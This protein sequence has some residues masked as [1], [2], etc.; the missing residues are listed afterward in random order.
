MEKSKLQLEKEVSDLKQHVRCN[1]MDHNQIEQ[2][3]KDIEERARQEI[4][5]K[6]EEVNLFLQVNLQILYYKSIVE[7]TCYKYSIDH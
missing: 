3:K 7:T 5:Q 1:L 2:Y 6:L 4:R